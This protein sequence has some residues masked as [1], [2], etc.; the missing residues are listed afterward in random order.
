[1]SEV[2]TQSQIDALLNSMQSGNDESKEADK[3][4]EHAKEKRDKKYDFHSP[5]KFTRDKLRVL[6]GIYENYSR[7]ASSR[8]NSVL[9]T[10]CQVG[11]LGIEEQR[12][13]EFSNSLN[14]NDV[15]TLIKVTTVDGKS[16]GPIVMKV[17]TQTMLLMMD[18]MLGGVSDEVE[19]DTMSYSYTDIEL[20]IY[21]II[22]KYLVDVMSD[23]WTNYI[24]DLEFEIDRIE[25]N[26]TMMQEVSRDESVAIIILEMEIGNYSGNINICLPDTVFSGMR[27]T[28]E[29]RSTRDSFTEEEKEETTRIIFDNIK[30]TSLEV[31]AELG[32]S[33]LLL[34]DVYSLQV[35][36]VINLNKPKDSEVYLTVSDQ[37]W[38][39]GYL[40]TSN[41]NMA[42]KIS[43]VY[44]KNN[45]LILS[46][47]GE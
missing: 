20:K 46:Q 41:K 5:K 22:V 31:K 12:Y 27:K 16:F 40:G 24:E 34:K 42:V 10:N 45:N 44:D 3:E 13:Y 39:K 15:L 7:I 4:K 29:K 6:N 23:G 19:E 8:I 38:F 2:L 11:I 37:T 25:T 17:D 28:I 1:M 21:G 47:K 18:K 43:D 14:E 32:K 35:G 33:R 36:D 30:K 9:R 26:P